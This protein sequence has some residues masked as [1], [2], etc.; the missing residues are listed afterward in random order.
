MDRDVTYG[1]DNGNR[2]LDFVRITAELH[3]LIESRDLEDDFISSYEEDKMEGTVNFLRVLGLS[4][5]S[6]LKNLYI[7]PNC[8]EDIAQKMLE[9]ADVEM[10]HND[11]NNDDLPQYY[12]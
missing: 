3:D 12:S 5:T 8:P 4:R 11:S 7:L 1:F 2:T 9:S 10:G 6:V